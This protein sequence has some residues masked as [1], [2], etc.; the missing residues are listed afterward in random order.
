LQEGEQDVKENVDP[1]QNVGGP[2]VEVAYTT[3]RENPNILEQNDDLEKNDNNTP[4]NPGGIL[5]LGKHYIND[6]GTTE[7]RLNVQRDI[8]RNYE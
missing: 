7:G 1:K 4:D 6:I 8:S 5:K 2:V 3:G